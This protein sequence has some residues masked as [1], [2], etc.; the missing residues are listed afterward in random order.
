L[1]NTIGGWTAD[2]ADEVSIDSLTKLNGRLDSRVHGYA[3][4]GNWTLPWLWGS[5]LTYPSGIYGEV[6]FREGVSAMA[7]CL[8]AEETNGHVYS[9]DIDSCETGRTNIRKA[10][11]DRRHTFIQGDS[12]VTKFPEPLDI[13]YIDG[14]H[15]YDQVKADFDLHYDNVK[16]GGIIFFHDPVIWPD[17]V[18]R[19]LEEKAIFTMPIGVGLGV[20]FKP[21]ERGQVS[22]RPE[23]SDCPVL[24][25][26]G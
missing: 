14:G 7:L 10:R 13:L 2:L 9:I 4:A 26:A 15:T 11:L 1:P 5:A 23:L 8:A 20:M 6:G 22:V 19:F 17:D 16:P 3:K 18:G 12:S 25:D 24:V 21:F